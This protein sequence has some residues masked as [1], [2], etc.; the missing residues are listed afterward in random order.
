MFK[1]KLYL[2]LILVVLFLSACGVPE[3]EAEIPLEI[4]TETDVIVEEAPV[5]EAEVS[6]AETSEKPDAE[7]IYV[8][9]IKESSLGWFGEKVIGKKHYGSVKI[10]EGTLV[11][12]N[13]T[14]VSGT[15]VMD[16]NSINVEDG[17]PQ[18]L[19]NHLKNDDFFGVNAHPTSTLEIISAKALGNDQYAVSATLTIKGISQPL[20]FIAIATEESG[21]ITASAEIVFDRTLYGIE[22][23]SASIFSDLGDKA[24]KD[25]I[26]ISVTLV[27]LEA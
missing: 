14:F 4:P 26:S 7:G 25:E 18:R 2:V 8:V 13:G 5:E 21:R 22:Y 19:E 20:D 3:P 23:D 27:A 12:E 16:M 9:D 11:V 15:V 10:L 6:E 1:K 24:I 17:S